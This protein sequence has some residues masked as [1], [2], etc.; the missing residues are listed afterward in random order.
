MKELPVWL[1]EPLRVLV[2]S[3]ATLHHALLFTGPE[4][5]GKEWLARGLAAALLC[6]EPAST[7]IACG[8]CP[9]CRWMSSD[10]HPDFR[11][12]RPSADE[13]Q[14]EEGESAGTR[15]TKP[16]RDIKIEQIRGLAGFVEVASHRGGE[17]IVL[18]TPAD[19]MNPP[20]ANS[21]LKTLEEPP[22]STRFL[23]VS[24]RVA[25]LPATVRSRCRTVPVAAPA[26]E[27]ALDWVVAQTRVNHEIARDW[28][29]FCGGAPRRAA[30]LAT[31][32]AS[33]RQRDLTEVFGGGDRLSL[34]EAADRLQSCEPREWV[35]V[36]HAWCC[37][38]AR[39][40]AGGS[41]RFFPG[42]GRRLAELAGFADNP[43]LL[44]LESWLQQTRRLVS[45]PLNARLVA[46]DALSRY[47]A[48]FSRTA[49]G[50]P[51]GRPSAAR[52]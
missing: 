16:S 29:A 43:R 30:E 48:V 34:A 22:P 21:L 44:A 28:L 10:S 38:L 7:G 4:G 42:E 49:A 5:V 23:L 46:E 52:A 26:S 25:R 33:A 31:P 8:R 19:A 2:A 20:A 15:S 37:D 12:I 11:C 6:D 50:A 39:C 35:P 32:E 24:S 9:S 3:R 45:H 18:I 51:G 40:R 14:A 1:S 13:A 36:L 27:H 47:R 41:P 17:K